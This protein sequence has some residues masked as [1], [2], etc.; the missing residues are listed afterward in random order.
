MY[1]KTLTN[2]RLQAKRERCAR[3]RAAKDRK[4]LET[5]GPWSDVGGIVTDG[6]LGRHTIR[7]L[8]CDSYSD[9]LLA[10]TVDG[11]QRRPR[12]LRGVVRC[13]A[14]LLFRPI[15]DRA[16]RNPPMHPPSAPLRLCG[17]NPGNRKT[18]DS[19]RPG[20]HTGRNP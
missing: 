4:R 3:A 1:R 12:T 2:K 8:A 18:G 9:R 13:L 10:V 16:A 6:C 5:G 15:Q 20:N 19:N 14:S 7:L 11:R 17:K